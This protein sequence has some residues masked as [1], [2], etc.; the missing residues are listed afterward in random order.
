MNSSAKFLLVVVGPTAVGK[1]SLCLK[2]AKKF[3]TEI[4]SAD[5][6][7]FYKETEIGTAK[8]SIKERSEVPHHFI[9]HKS[10]FDSYDVK[11]FEK[12]TL[13]LLEKLFENKDL[14]ILTGGS[15]LFV[16]VVC[17]GMDEIPGVEPGIRKAL[18]ELYE[19]KGIEHLQSELRQVDPAYYQEVDLKNPQRLMRALEV[20]RA[21]GKPYSSF[22]K[23]HKQQRP[24]EVIK[25][26][27]KRERADLYQRIDLR[28]DQMIEEGL[29]EEAYSLFPFRYLNALQ[30][31]GYSE[32]FGYLEGKYDKEEAIRLLKRNSR[33]YAKRQM[34]WFRR[35][36]EITWFHPE[37]EHDV[38]AFIRERVQ[39]K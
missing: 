17:N 7:Q 8:P 36:Q 22:R 34:T 5:S 26:G 13:K 31:V 33:R 18:I 9:G 2:L 32:I 4:I 21:T 29:F 30:T 12:D 15:G 27:L 25:V 3:N 6:R 11:I 39:N 28:M 19:H 16:D 14:V 23:K 37:E 1:T 24:F 35:D 20:S 38:F 10:I